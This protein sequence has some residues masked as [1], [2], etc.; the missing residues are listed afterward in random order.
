MMNNNWK[1]K[2]LGDFTMETSTMRVS[3]PCYTKDVWC[4]G[5]LENCAAG[6]WTAN[7]K[8][9]EYHTFG[10]RVALLVVR[11]K[12]CQRDLKFLR[13]VGLQCPKGFYLMDDLVGVDSGR[14]GFFDDKYYGTSAGTTEPR[15]DFANK[16]EEAEYWFDAC[17]DATL[18]D[19]RAGVLPY[20]AVSQSGMG[21]GEYLC[22][23]H[24]NE[25]GLV[26]MAILRYL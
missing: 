2:K 5:T 24:E 26:D 17:C 10:R 4:S 8:I 13:A 1:W 14:A 9:G 23:F 11:H 16:I 12:D 18:S 3:D 21:D 6:T 15:N 22:Y 20:G 25:A 19:K 7:I